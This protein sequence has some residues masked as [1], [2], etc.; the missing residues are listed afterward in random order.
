M[1][2]ADTLR[3]FLAVPAPPAWVESARE[4]VA[5]LRSEMPEASWTRPESWHITLHFLGEISRA[6]ADRFAAE[7][8]PI[9]E[10]ASGGDLE[11][12]GAVVFPQRGPARVLAVGFA[13]SATT[14][15]LGRLAASAGGSKIQKRF[16]PHVTLARLRRPWPHEAVLRFQNELSRW[17]PP[18]WRAESCVLFQ[19][20]LGPGG[21]VHTPLHSF[22]LARVPVEVLH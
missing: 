20:R 3:V 6:Q 12:S 1:I 11:A 13:E 16:A 8:A 5:R 19:S 18:A 21:A 4:L 22:S 9:I 17:R 14:A 7:I 15:S 10:A 2:E